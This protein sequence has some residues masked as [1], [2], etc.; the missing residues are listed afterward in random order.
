[1]LPLIM[2]PPPLKEKLNGVAD[3]LGCPVDEEKYASY[4]CRQETS[5]SSSGNVSHNQPHKSSVS[6]RCSSIDVRLQTATSESPYQHYYS[7]IG[8]SSYGCQLR[9]CSFPLCRTWVFVTVLIKSQNLAL[10]S[11]IFTWIHK[12]IFFAFSGLLCIVYPVTA[13]GQD[14]EPKFLSCVNTD[15]IDL[16]TYPTQEPQTLFHSMYSMVSQWIFM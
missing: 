2:P 14:A 7:R 4:F 5:L 6:P 15:C 12:V 10:N 9:R 3:R 16:P 8:T 1:M 13:S 11:T